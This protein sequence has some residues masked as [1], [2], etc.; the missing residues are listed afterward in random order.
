MSTKETLVAARELIAEPENWCQGELRRVNDDGSVAYCALGAVSAT[1][2]DI[3]HLF[4]SDALTALRELVPGGA[5]ARYNNSHSHE[6]VVALFD[7]AI[8]RQS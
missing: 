6:C 4:N 2:L 5:I 3:R 8:A 7:E 1:G